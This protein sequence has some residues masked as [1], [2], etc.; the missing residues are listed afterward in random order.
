MLTVGRGV[1]DVPFLRFSD[2]WKPRLQRRN[3]FP[4]LTVRARSSIVQRLVVVIEDRGWQLQGRGQDLLQTGAVGGAGDDGAAV[5][6]RAQRE[7]L[8]EWRNR[9]KRLFFNETFREIG[10]RPSVGFGAHCR[11]ERPVVGV[12]SSSRD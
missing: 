10:D 1:A 6:Q 7:E 12:I 2:S 8:A 9:S 11:C 4:M 5:A 3:D